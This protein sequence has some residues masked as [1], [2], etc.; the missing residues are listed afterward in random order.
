[1]SKLL[2]EEERKYLVIYNMGLPDYKISCKRDAAFGKIVTSLQI[3]KDK[4]NM[5]ILYIFSLKTLF[6]L[7]CAL[8]VDTDRV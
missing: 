1:M 7:G 2:I 6:F 5:Y 8:I 3:K 4:S